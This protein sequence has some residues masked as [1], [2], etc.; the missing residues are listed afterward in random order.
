ML[1]MVGNRKYLEEK[2]V[3]DL[4]DAYGRVGKEQRNFRVYEEILST[5]ERY[6]KV[7]EDIDVLDEKEARING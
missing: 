7:I 1:V 3:I 2:G 6:G 5:I 4:P